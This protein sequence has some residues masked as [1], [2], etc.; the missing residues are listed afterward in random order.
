MVNASIEATNDLQI[1]E[2]QFWDYFW[3]EDPIWANNGYYTTISISDLSGQYENISKNN[4]SI[5]GTGIN[6]LSGT[7]NPRVQI[8]SNLNNYQS[9]GEPITY[10]KR[11]TASNFSIKGKYGN[12]PRLKF[13]IPAYI[14]IDDYHATLTYTLYEN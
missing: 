6:L 10:I 5:K 14:R 12:K 2:Q 7:A 3:V 4:I 8:N 9:I 13:D 11:D 1:V